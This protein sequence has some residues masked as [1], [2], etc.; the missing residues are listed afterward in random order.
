M[1]SFR[2]TFVIFLHQV[3]EQWQDREQCS[4]LRNLP[5]MPFGRLLGLLVYT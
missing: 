1:S 5:A 3:V 2:F 4:H